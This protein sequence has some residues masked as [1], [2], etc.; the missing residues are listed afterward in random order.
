VR[1]AR[2]RQAEPE[3]VEAY[4]PSAYSVLC[5]HEG[6]VIIRGTDNAGWT[7][8]DYVL[9]RLASGLM[10]GDEIT[11]DE[12]WASNASEILAAQIESVEDSQC[13]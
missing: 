7:L 5:T 1:Y 9:P 10:F 6:D 2:I 4:L 12:A 8:D 13:N 11:H 3:R